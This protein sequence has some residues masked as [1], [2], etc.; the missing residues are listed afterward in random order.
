VKRFPLEPL[1]T[2]VVLAVAALS[3][4]AATPAKK[5]PT[6]APGN[7]CAVCV[8]KRPILD[9]K[10]FTTGYEPE[11]RRGYEIAREMPATL[12]LLHCFCECKESPVFHHRTLLTCYTD[13]HA[14][15]CGICLREA[16]MAADL[17]KQG[18]SDEQIE[19]LVEGSFKTDG[20]GPT[21]GRG[22]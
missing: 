22:Q 5:A 13:Q 15:G 7:G 19:A 16:M 2:L 4:A 11:A 1:H 17:K 6:A 21:A 12:D 8:E 20:H 3:V 9:P 10:L 18:A 14:A